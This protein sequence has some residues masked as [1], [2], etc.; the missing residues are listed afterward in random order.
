MRTS[1]YLLRAARI[2][3]AAFTLATAAAQD[4]VIPEGVF[5]AGTTIMD[6]RDRPWAYLYLSAPEDATLRGR[7]LAVYVKPGAATSAAEFQ[8]QGTIAPATDPAIASAYLDRAV[9]LGGNRAEIEKS[10]LGLYRMAKYPG[11]LARLN[12]ERQP[13]DP[14]WPDDPPAAGEASVP[15]QIAMVVGRAATDPEIAEMLQLGSVA[16]P[17]FAMAMGRGW[18]GLLPVRQGD[19][20]TIEVRVREGNTD[21]GVV[22]RVELIAGIALPMPPPGAPV[23]RIDPTPSGDRNIQLRWATPAEL[24]RYSLLSVGYN[25]YRMPAEFAIASRFDVTPPPTDLLLALVRDRPQDAVQVNRGMILPPKLFREEDVANFQAPPAGDPETRFFVD[26]ND[27]CCDGVEHL[28]FEDGARFYYFAAARDLLGRVGEISPGGAAQACRRIAPQVPTGMLAKAA[29]VSVSPASHVV[30]LSWQ[31]SDP[32]GTPVSHYEILRGVG[33]GDPRIGGAI[34]DGSLLEAFDSSKLAVYR[35]VLP[36]ASPDGLQ[37]WTDEAPFIQPGQTCW[38]AV[39]AVFVGGCGRLISAP[40]P[41]AFASLRQL[42]APDPPSLCYQGNSSPYALVAHWDNESASEIYPGGEFRVRAVCRRMNGG[43]TSVRFLLA[44]DIGNQQIRQ[45]QTVYFPEWTGQG[46]SDATADFIFTGTGPSGNARVSCIATSG[47]GAV[48]LEA[49]GTAA[50]PTAV[51]SMGRKTTLPLIAFQAGAYSIATPPPPGL[52]RNQILSASTAAPSEAPVVGNGVT[53]VKFNLGGGATPATP[54]GYRELPSVLVERSGPTGWTTIG[55]A[56]LSTAGVLLAGEFREPLRATLLHTILPEN[57][58]CTHQRDGEGGAT[59][60]LNLGICLTPGSAEYRLYRQIDDGGLSLISQGPAVYQQAGDQVRFADT[61][62]PLASGR[63]YYYAQLVNRNG[64]A[65]PM[66]SLNLCPLLLAAPLPVPELLRPKPALDAEGRANLQ[67]DWFCP[68]PGVERFQV[69]LESEINLLNLQYFTDLPEAFVGIVPSVSGRGPRDVPTATPL[70][71]LPFEAGASHIL[72]RNNSL[73]TGRFT[74]VRRFYTP[75]IGAPPEG[76]GNGPAFTVRTPVQR[77]VKYRVWVKAVGPTGG[78]SGPSKVQE[79][80]WNTPERETPSEDPKVPWP[81][82]ELPPR[83]AGEVFDPPVEAADLF[84]PPGGS[85]FVW[86]PNPDQRYNV[87]IRIGGVPAIGSDQYE[88]FENADLG[89][90]FQLTNSTTGVVDLLGRTNPNLHLS[91][92]TDGTL[93]PVLPA[94]LYR[95]QVPSKAYPAAPGETIQVSPLIEHIG[96]EAAGKGNDARII[97]PFIGVV[98]GRNGG[99]APHQVLFYLLDT[100]PVVEGAKYHYFLV[101]FGANGEMKDVIDAGQ[102]EIKPK[103]EQ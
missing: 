47:A 10:F 87:G 98:A 22:G 81:D 62:L 59:V 11:Y 91:R 7:Q 19:P 4:T 82:R 97:D 28:P 75:R 36:V 88:A 89:A 85:E 16:S 44:A 96:W 60:P 20:V 92:K 3:C 77:N 71:E 95:R 43:V 12:R 93:D 5:T 49:S 46:N 73:L 34:N 45:E 17:A 76:L 37:Q 13:G 100:Q 61:S 8:L 30:R 80:I 31:A 101:R 18:G 64:N 35:E 33:K 39:R 74:S 79:F 99:S 2:V 50:L 68:P 26:Q 86:P 69:F 48:S 24:R 58:L 65:S 9:S 27:R 63:V 66:I 14:P 67:L 41:P 56:K 15:E 23:Q 1:S 21:G 103:S 70:R 90:V 32:A 25:L 53:V 78:V 6:G 102:I 83:F 55:G 94:V 84:Y 57:S 54:P 42:T 38:Y 72:S 29:T 52:L 51:N 40:T